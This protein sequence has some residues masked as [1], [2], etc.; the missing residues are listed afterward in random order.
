MSTIVIFHHHQQLIGGLRSSVCDLQRQ[1]EG[2]VQE[3][4]G[5]FGGVIEVGTCPG[6]AASGAARAH[7]PTHPTCSDTG[8]PFAVR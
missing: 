6:G 7:I 3:N 8:L 4:F 2:G 5:K 1:V